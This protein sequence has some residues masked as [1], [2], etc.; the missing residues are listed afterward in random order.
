MDM[1]FMGAIG[2]FLLLVWLLAAG[3]EKLGKRP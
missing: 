3:C 2:V 1:L